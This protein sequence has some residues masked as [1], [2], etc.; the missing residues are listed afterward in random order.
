M[1]GIAIV[2]G[3]PGAGKTTLIARLLESNKSRLIQAS[4]CLKEPGL[5]QWKQEYASDSGRRKS[6]HAELQRWLDAGAVLAA[7]LTYDPDRVDLESVLC[8]ANGDFDE[9]DEW[10]VEGENVENSR[11][12]CSVYVLRPL[13][14]SAPLVE[15]T[16]RVVAHIPLE[17]YLRYG[18]G[19]PPGESIEPSDDEV[20]EEVGTEIPLDEKLPERL[21]EA[22]VEL[23]KPE[24]DR[25]RSLVQDGVPVRSKQPDLRADCARMLAAEVVVINLHAEK[26]RAAAQATRAQIL[27]L[28]RNWSLRYRIPFRSHVTRAGIY[29]AN[30]HNTS[31]PEL[32]RAIA[33][34]KRKLRGR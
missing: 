34:I 29:L 12:A 2:D 11:A 4:R 14:E 22:G 8:E 20:L 3:Q 10:L 7:L 17:D 27:D 15:E 9:W 13:P 28:Y 6:S 18:C 25:L 30:L 5:Q 24:R 1:P 16:E 26:E 31:D 32:Q 23:S 21:A 19:L 33:Q